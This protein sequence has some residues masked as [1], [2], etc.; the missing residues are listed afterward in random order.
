MSLEDNNW[1][2]I[3]N[4]KEYS[5]HIKNYLNS[6]NLVARGEVNIKKTPEEILDYIIN[7]R[8]NWDE[9]F[10]EGKIIER[11][12]ESTSIEHNIFKGLLFVGS[13]DICI[14]FSKLIIQ[15]TH[16]LIACSIAD[17]RVPE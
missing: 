8:K 11:I 12:S 2:E 14:L 17:D 7:N 15:N 13:R 10:K 9:M 3:K 5:I 6:G 1:K 16:Y 4:K